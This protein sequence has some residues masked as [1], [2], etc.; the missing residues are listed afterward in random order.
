[1]IILYILKFKKYDFR[2]HEIVV[3]DILDRQ[4][5]TLTYDQ[6]KEMKYFHGVK[7]TPAHF[8]IKIGG[9]KYRVESTGTEPGNLEFMRWIGERNPNIILTAFDKS[10]RFYHDL[11]SS[12]DKVR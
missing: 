7:G 8:T 11:T 3:H 2:E 5:A 9:S 10:S 12:S 6:I 1:M 4:T